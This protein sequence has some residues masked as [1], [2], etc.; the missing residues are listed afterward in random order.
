MSG[1][2]FEIIILLVVAVVLLVRLIGTLG[3]RDGF[4]PP[5][6]TAPRPQSG[7]HL[8]LV[9]DEEDFDIEQF[10]GGN[11]EIAGAL[12]EAKKIEPE[13]RVGEFFD[14]AKRA[15][16]MILMGFL[17]GELDDVKPFVDKDVYSGFEKA[18]EERNKR[19]ESIEA[20]F[21]GIRDVALKSAE[22]D[23]KSKELVLGVEY[24]AELSRQVLDKTGKVLSGDGK[25]RETEVDYWE[26]SRVMGSDNPNWR[27]VATGE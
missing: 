14:G 25:K 24:V 3:T 12:R 18:I 11:E 4:E 19:G 2:G 23:R 26:F 13:F 5:V 27:L 15:Y 16:E 20:T 17:G 21:A 22:F 9:D 10:A 7:E 1:I 6:Q 8:R